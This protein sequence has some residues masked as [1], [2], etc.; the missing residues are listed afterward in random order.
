LKKKGI[1]EAAR[2][3][4]GYEEKKN[5]V[6]EGRRKREC[7]FL[8]ARHRKDFRNRE[9][10]RR[11]PNGKGGT[12][13]ERKDFAAMSKKNKGVVVHESAL[14][15]GKFEAKL[16][17][18]S[19]RKEAEQ[20]SRGSHAALQTFF[21]QGLAGTCIERGRHYT[22]R[23]NNSLGRREEV[24]LTDHLRLK[25]KKRG[26]KS[27]TLPGPDGKKEKDTPTTIGEEMTPSSKRG[28]P[29]A[30]QNTSRKA[31]DCFRSEEEKKKKG[32]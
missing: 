1:V 11:R 27:Q 12:E 19:P 2:G 15:K 25:K 7:A 5:R 10:H 30:R 29:N 13:S 23:E 20:A 28:G 24:P 8:D 6:F 31:K 32:H 21:W 4:E 3:Q 9:D 18:H 14:E 16:A 22:R 17:K 26:T